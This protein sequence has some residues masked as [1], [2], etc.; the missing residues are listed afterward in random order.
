MGSRWLMGGLIA[1][2]VLNLFLVGAAVGVIVMGRSMAVANAGARPGALFEATATLP[3]PDRHDFR[4]MLR[5]ARQAVMPDVNRS[6]Q[7]RVEAWTSLGDA[8]ADASGIKSRLAQSRQLD[9]GVRAKLEEKIVDY[10]MRLPMSDRTAFA[11]GMR[12]AL[13]PPATSPP[14]ANAAE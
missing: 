11:A 3:Q 13:A 5:Q 2:L 8:T 9:A 1:S 4:G 7:L 6:R 14:A 12:R 10:V